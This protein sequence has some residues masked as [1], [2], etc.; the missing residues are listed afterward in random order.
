M[1]VSRDK[2]LSR[3]RDDQ[4][5][6]FVKRQG[7]SVEKVCQETVDDR[8]KEFVKRRW[9]ISQRSLCRGTVDDVTMR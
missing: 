5:R 2:S 8:S 7:R 9:T 6:K 4:S 3:D 1:K